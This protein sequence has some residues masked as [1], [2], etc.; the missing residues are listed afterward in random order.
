MAIGNCKCL[1]AQNLMQSPVPNNLH[2]WDIHD[3][4]ALI[5]LQCTGTSIYNPNCLLHSAKLYLTCY[6]L[7]FVH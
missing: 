1:I 5:F 2:F 6:C 3:L 7:M 4:L